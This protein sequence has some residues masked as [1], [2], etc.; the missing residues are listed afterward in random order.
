MDVMSVLKR[1]TKVYNIESVYDRSDAHLGHGARIPYLH[2]LIVGALRTEAGRKKER[3]QK[4]KCGYLTN[5]K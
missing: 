5:R 1:D 2:H 3:R 4:T